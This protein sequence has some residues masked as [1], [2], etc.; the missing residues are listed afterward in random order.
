MEV[1]RK[2]FY[3][4]LTYDEW[5]SQQDK[6]SL[7]FKAI[8]TYH[9]TRPEYSLEETRNK[10]FLNAIEAEEVK[11]SSKQ[12]SDLESK[13]IQE[14]Q[15]V[16]PNWALDDIKGFA[17]RFVATY[18]KILQKINKDDSTLNMQDIEKRA[19]NYI[20]AG[21]RGNKVHEEVFGEDVPVDDYNFLA[22]WNTNLGKI[23]KILIEGATGYNPE[24]YKHSSIQS[25]KWAGYSYGFRSEM[26][27][28]RD[29]KEIIE[30]NRERY[31]TKS[32]FFKELIFKG[33]AIYSIINKGRLGEMADNILGDVERFE[34]LGNDAKIESILRDMR[35]FFKE[36]NDKLRIIER[37]KKALEV[38]RDKVTKYVSDRLS[39]YCDEEDKE[40]MRQEIMENKDLDMV[41]LS[42]ERQNLVS[43]EYREKLTR[44]GIIV[45]NINIVADNDVND[46]QG[47]K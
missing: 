23:M 22:K 13:I 32:D 5:T 36:R 39:Y 41:L 11:K 7:E 43:R 40:M 4:G 10:I 25:I 46:K 28:D 47:Y 30:L 27:L 33:V 42:L 20:N 12:Y 45:S 29:I 24:D 3:D 38:F 44:E 14:I 17:P 2:I 6:D 1:E 8:D 37:N 16:Y 15:N 21:I 34:R 9:K 19:I 31:G 35:Q 26:E 18:V